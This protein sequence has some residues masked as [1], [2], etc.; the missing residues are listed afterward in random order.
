LQIERG[1]DKLVALPSTMRA[2][3][4][5]TTAALASIAWLAARPAVANIYSYTDEQG[6]L[7]FTN[8][9]PPAAK[10]TKWRLLSSGP[11]KALTVSGASSAGCRVSRADVVPARDRSPDRY[12]RYDPFIAYAARLYA[13][14]EALIRAIIKVESDYDPQVVS[15]AGA[16]GLMQVMP[17]EEKSEHIE[18]VFDP[19]QNIMAGTRMLRSK[20]NHWNGDLVKT[21]ASYHAG[22]GAVAKYHGVPPY[23]TTQQYV[24]SVLKYY[25]K[26]RER[27]VASR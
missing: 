15:C 10:R 22:V 25:E 7:H 21:I 20:A 26:Y 14:P 12:V 18:H 27:E 24:K 19:W 9:E 11:G 13:I 2:P 16:K 17:Y 1:D 6:I 4:R 23:E 8:V 5:F 3:R